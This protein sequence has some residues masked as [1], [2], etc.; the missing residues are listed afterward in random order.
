MLFNGK[1]E[2]AQLL[3]DD[4]QAVWLLQSRV[5]FARIEF[6]LILAGYNPKTRSFESRAYLIYVILFFSAWIFATLTLLADAGKILLE[7]LPFGG[8]LPSAMWLGLLGFCA[9]FL[10]EL[11]K[12][13]RR[14]PFIF[15]EADAHYLCSSPLDRRPVAIAWLLKNW[16]T[17]AIVI[18]PGAVVL[19]YALLEAQ[20]LRELTTADLPRYFLA[21]LRM[22]LISVPLHLGLH[23]LAWS[24]GALRL[25]ERLYLPP[26]R[27]MT[28]L[29]SVGFAGVW[30]L[31]GALGGNF[32]PGWLEPLSFP[33]QAGLGAAVLLPGLGL[34]GVWMALGLACLWK[35]APGVSLTKAA[36]ETKGMEAMKAAM[37]LGASDLA[38]E[39]K[40]RQ[41]LGA[42]KKTSRFLMGEGR[43]ALVSR[44]VVQALRGWSVAQLG[45]WL[46]ILSLSLGILLPS[47]WE[48]R[49][50]LC[51]VW[52]LAVGQRVAVPVQRDLK[53]WWLMN[54]LPYP[55]DGLV[56]TSLMQPI[57]GASVLA[58]LAMGG[59]GLMGTALP[60]YV[61]V[62]VIPLIVG[63]AFST[64]LDVLRQCHTTRLLAGM[65]P[66]LTF[67]TVVLGVLVV[68]VSV[69]SG[70]LLVE[71]WAL[72]LWVWMPL[73][74]AVSAGLDYGLLILIRRQ[75]HRLRWP[76][77][78]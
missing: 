6:W 73:V 53:S 16:L 49:A 10:I 31:T 69:G 46:M 1:S 54:Q 8:P 40:Q 34:A 28:L 4:I 61:W 45:P 23:S 68:I 64:L 65:A 13:A 77:R 56:I 35:L 58:L 32:L 2:M 62:I 33:I 60:A 17:S 7:N 24:L 39:L 47:G 44:N 50:F 59:V 27:W 74:L 41:R 3:S 30:L 71:R 22:L 26:L 11:N 72:P 19:A 12:S 38:Q 29:V 25:Q 21:G 67:L 75:M 70:W 5:S 20:A 57:A 66:D 76:L 55:M 51:L 37:L 48:A 18:W 42:G 14:S 52:I 9:F 36:Q 43:W 78:S 63:I 15:S